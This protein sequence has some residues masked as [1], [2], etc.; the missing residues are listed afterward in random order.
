[1]KAAD[2]YKLTSRQQKTM[3]MAMYL[4]NALEDFHVANLSDSQ[5]KELNQL[6]RQALYNATSI[7]ETDE[8]DVWRERMM[9]YLVGMI[10]DYW[11]VPEDE[12][13]R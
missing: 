1:M 4:R 13:W 8:S 2:F 11:E 3:L 10:P 6:L 7:L 5:M 9:G 12:T